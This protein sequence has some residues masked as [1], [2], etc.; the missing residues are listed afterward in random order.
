MSPSLQVLEKWYP[1]RELG[2]KKAVLLVVKTSKEG[3]LSA[4]PGFSKVLGNLV[5]SV[6]GDN[7][8]VYAEQEKFNEAI[9]SSLARIE[10]KLKGKADPGAPS[11]ATKQT[12]SNFKSKEQTEDKKGIYTTVVGGLLARTGSQLLLSGENAAG[13]T[14]TLPESRVV[15]LWQVI[16]FVVPMVQYYGAPLVGSCVGTTLYRHPRRSAAHVR[17][18]PNHATPQSQCRLHRQGE[19]IYYSRVADRRWSSCAH[20]LRAGQQYGMRPPVCEAACGSSS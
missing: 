1:T 14:D 5:D 18:V 20:M 15:P 3:A 2:D 11:V 13:Y 19:V 7:I 8:P 4:G 16:A 9:T 6:S 12:G 17:G 10:A